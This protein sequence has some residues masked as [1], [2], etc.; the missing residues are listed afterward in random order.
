MEI[1]IRHLQKCIKIDLHPQTEDISKKICKCLCLSYKSYCM[2]ISKDL[3]LLDSED[4]K[5]YSCFLQY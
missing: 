1:K 4:C 5:F 2:E 3:L